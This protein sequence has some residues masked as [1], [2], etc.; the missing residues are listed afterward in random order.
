MGFKSFVAA[1]VT[2]AALSVA[3]PAGA[4]TLTFLVTVDSTSDGSTAPAAFYQSWE[5][6][7]AASQS[8]SIVA[9]FP[10]F[11][12][13]ERKTI[14]DRFG[15]Q[16]VVSDTRATNP[17][18]ALTD[19][20]GVSP[21][22]STATFRNRH[23][24]LD[25][26]PSTE[27]TEAEFNLTINS[28]GQTAGADTAGDVSDDVFEYASYSAYLF[29]ALGNYSPPALGLPSFIDFIL[30][31]GP[32]AY[33]ERGSVTVVGSTYSS[34]TVQ[35]DGTARLFAVDGREV[36]GGTAPPVPEPASWAL[37]ILGFGAA[38]ALLRRRSLASA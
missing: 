14:T 5:F 28:S 27:N 18:L 33:T 16:A 23:V 24:F 34:T 6:T 12:I 9:G 7:G 10:D 26:V 21:T 29:A 19:L 37:M 36:G 13:P 3:A 22:S 4:V 38:G 25:G 11:G 20:D 17:L 30:D 8:T 15:G 35:Y 31:Q 32:L 1:A 2:V